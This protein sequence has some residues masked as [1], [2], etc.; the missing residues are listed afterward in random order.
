MLRPKADQQVCIEVPGK[1][2]N[3]DDFGS[4]IDKTFTTQEARK[5]CHGG[6]Y[7]GKEYEPCPVAH[8]CYVATVGTR[9]ARSLPQLNP[10]GATI[11]TPPP[12]SKKERVFSLDDFEIPKLDF[13]LGDFGLPNMTQIP[14]A[15]EEEKPAKPKTV[16]EHVRATVAEFL[17]DH[18]SRRVAQPLDGALPGMRT[19]FL[20][21]SQKH[22]EASPPTFLPTGV[23]STWD[24]LFKNIVQGI[25]AAI[26]FAIWQF[27]RTIDLF[28]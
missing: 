18:D 8:E 21:G 25:I 17:R 15:K 26:G 7:L 10:Q 11:V 22:A 24:R 23:E 20:S 4:F 27:A 9:R 12:P 2:Q 6:V 28:G 14:Q 3:C 5:M 16:E 13:S 19:P 1:M